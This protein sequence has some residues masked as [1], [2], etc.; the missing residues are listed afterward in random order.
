LAQV[1]P[2][3]AL[4]F[5]ANVMVDICPVCQEDLVLPAF[6]RQTLQCGHVLHERCVTQMRRMGSSGRCPVCRRTDD[7]LTPLQ[8]L[9]EDG[10]SLFHLG[11]YSSALDTLMK[12]QSVDAGNVVV[13]DALAMCFSKQ[14]NQERAAELYDEAWRGGRVEAAFNHGVM[15]EQQGDLVKA[16][17]LYQKAS[18]AGDADAAFNLSGV[19]LR[20]GQLGK[21]VVA[22]KLAYQ[23]GYP[24]AVV[25]LGFIYR[26]L[27]DFFAAVDC[28]AEAHRSGNID[29]TYNLGLCLEKIGDVEAALE[30]FEDGHLSGD[31]QCTCCLSQLCVELGDYDHAYELLMTARQRGS[32]EAICQLGV[33]CGKCG[34]PENERA[35]FEEAHE[36]GCLAATYNLGVWHQRHGDL[37]RAQVLWEQAHQGGEV[38]AT[39]NLAVLMRRL[40]NVERSQELFELARCSNDKEAIVPHRFDTHGHV[41]V[42]QL[43]K[44]ALGTTGPFHSIGSAEKKLSKRAKQK[45]RRKADRAAWEAEVD[46][47][48]AE[49]ALAKAPPALT[50]ADPEDFATQVAIESSFNEIR[51]TSQSSHSAE[52]VNSQLSSALVHDRQAGPSVTLLNFSRSPCAFRYALMHA[53]ELESIRQSLEAHGLPMELESGAKLV[54]HAKNYQAVLEAIRLGSLRATRSHVFVEPELEDVVI[55]LVR[56]LPRLHSVNHR[57]SAKVP[58]GAAQAVS[59]LDAE[60]RVE[61][62]FISIVVP[63]SL[64]SA[65]GIG[66]RTASTT[67]TTIRKGRNHRRASHK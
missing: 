33:L 4:R 9:L 30:V 56:A 22:A 5:C 59:E 57:S 29:G 66:P 10:I 15:M 60:V 54:V 34:E 62:T 17:E 63:S 37:D 45:A 47:S 2:A 48:R 42:S 1:F 52:H 51:L 18:D 50:H 46:R 55:G 61:R 24:F 25:R 38:G 14:G 36:K 65:G 40:G 44:E 31:L 39:Y 53:P 11:Q 58:I 6:G 41:A 13:M 3:D 67:D 43:A 7:D 27:G 32:I 64:R 12:A 8:Q 35:L 19:F 28:Y 16:Q 23:R 20:Q 49:S 21:S 26:K